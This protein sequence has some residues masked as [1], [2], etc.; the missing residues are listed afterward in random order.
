VP[1]NPPGRFAK[2]PTDLEPLAARLG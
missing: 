2:L 1:W